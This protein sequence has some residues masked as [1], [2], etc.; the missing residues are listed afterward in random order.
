MISLFQKLIFL[1]RIVSQKS[2]GVF[3]V[4]FIRKS[5]HNKAVEFNNM[6]FRTLKKTL[7][8]SIVLLQ[9]FLLQSYSPI[10]TTNCDTVP[11]LN[12]KVIDFVKTKL[13]KKVGEGECWDLAA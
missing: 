9:I 5:E 10:C 12:Q 4:I 13:N 8:G 11:E 1:K 6:H 3:L 7:L 2:I